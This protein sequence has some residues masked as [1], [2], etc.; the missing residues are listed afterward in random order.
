VPEKSL[1]I[2]IRASSGEGPKALRAFVGAELPALHRRLRS[3][4]AILFRGYGVTEP[5]ELAGL[6]AATGDESLRYVGGDS[7]RTAVGDGVYTSTETPAS[8]RVPLHNELSYLS[9]YPRQLWFACVQPA[10]QGGETTLADGRAILRNLDPTVRERFI[11]RG[12]RYHL[13]YRGRSLFY[14]LLDRIQKVTKTWMEAFETSDRTLVT[15]RCRRL[16]TSHRWLPSGRLVLQIHR[17]AVL[18]CDEELT[19]FNQAHLFHL[20]PRYLGNIHYWLARLLFC[21]PDS[22]SHD[23]CFGDGSEIDRA[24]I[25]HLFDVMERQTVAVEWQRGDV[26][27][28]DNLVCLHGRNPF[29]GARRVIVTMS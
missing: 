2:V 26:L 3:A 27:W 16:A 20:N 15:E 1:P 10:G 29:R 22:Q 14:S 24:T 4:G 23:A 21:T 17:P 6:L 7:P 5:S 11:D 25:N 8:I 12:V 13:S 28:I 19:W 9:S 18:S